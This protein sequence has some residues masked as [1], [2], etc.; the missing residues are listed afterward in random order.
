MRNLY[1]VP[2]KQW[3][4]WSDLAR[5]VFNATYN[6]MMDNTKVMIHPK[7]PMP[8]P[9]HFKTIAWNAA[10]IAADAVDDVIPNS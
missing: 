2:K 4:K 8:K 7:S 1:R 6:F 9:V 10:W 3:R 5:K